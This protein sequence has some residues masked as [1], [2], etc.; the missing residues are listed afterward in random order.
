[1]KSTPS[2]V[3]RE[4]IMRLRYAYIDKLP[5]ILDEVKRACEQLAASP[6]EADTLDTLHRSF[7]NLKGTAASLGLPEISAEGAVGTDLLGRLKG[8][9]AAERRSAVTAA[10]GELAACI[11]RLDNLKDSAAI[12][13]APVTAP[14]SEAA[15]A[16]AAEPA[17]QRRVVFF[18][19]KD[20]DGSALGAQLSCFG[21]T[22]SSF[23]NAEAMKAEVLA[24]P[25]DAVVMSTAGAKL[26]ADLRST[27][28]VPILF[29]SERTDFPTRLEA[30]KAGGEAYFVKP[31]TA[32]EVVDALDAVTVRRE[33]EPFRVLIIDD[34]PEMG[35][36]HALILEGAG[37]MVRR[38][39]DATRVL[40]ELNEFQPDLLLMD[41]YMPSC[42]GRELSRVIRQIPKFVSLPIIFLSSETDRLVQVSAMRVGADGFLTKPIPP[43]DLVTAVAVRAER[44]RV[45]RALM[46]R[47]SLTG[48]LNHTTLAQFL[49]TAL[50]NAL[51]QDSRLC[52]VML[53]LD[54]F[55]KVN[56][57]YGHPAGDQVLVA[58][59]RLL[60]Q[61]L[62]TSDVIGRYG[63]EEF[64][65]ILWNL[66]IDEAVRVIDHIRRDFSALTFKADETVFSCSFSGGVAAFPEHPTAEAIVQAADRALYAAKE[67][68][69]GRIAPAA[70]AGQAEARP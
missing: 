19:D 26:F 16:A 5:R 33:P 6:Q 14:W 12:A 2:P 34:E 68:G 51:R 30:I 65:A 11:E 23:I 9:D 70:A 31:V 18:C 42:S 40:E 47:D 58:L 57:T 49:D 8:L 39:D 64:A 56:D 46:M 54:E 62:R 41:M 10:V 29:V 32:H 43:E 25:P 27:V 37:M 63:G 3:L 4:R 17:V 35:D 15:V 67:K 44:T 59:A 45:L 48:L 13:A 24:A 20:L 21:Y 66:S 36:Y 52:F 50:A 28:A 38:L 69:R 1:M 55:K 61:R 22:F 7:H 53:D 60:K